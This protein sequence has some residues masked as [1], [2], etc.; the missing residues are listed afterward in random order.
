M[1]PLMANGVIWSEAFQQV[2]AATQIFPFPTENARFMCSISLYSGRGLFHF[3]L[4]ALDL[5]FFFFL[6]TT[7]ILIDVKP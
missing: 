1:K 6:P 2:E 4:P 3:H 7:I 5:S